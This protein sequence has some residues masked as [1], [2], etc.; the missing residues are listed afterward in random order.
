MKSII[1]AAFVATGALV[2][3]PAYSLS[4]ARDI[5]VRGDPEKAERTIHVTPDTR[6]I[7][8]SGSETVNLDV[9]GAMT[10]WKFN[11]RKEFVK[12]QDIIPGAPD[13]NVHVGPAADH[14]PAKG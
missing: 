4:D 11:G 12:L 10:P 6:D 14:S 3:S 5:G 13:V 7:A 2:I 9:D 8:V 1:T